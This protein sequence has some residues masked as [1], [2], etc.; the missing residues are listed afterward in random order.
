M[1]IF[2]N[3]IGEFVRVKESKRTWLKITEVAGDSHQET[4]T[5]IPYYQPAPKS[6]LRKKNIFSK[7]YKRLK[8]TSGN[9]EE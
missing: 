7:N 5:L 8:L 3:K 9:K 4:I 1:S 2:R 6:Q